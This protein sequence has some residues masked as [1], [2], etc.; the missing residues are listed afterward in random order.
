MLC[1]SLSH[2]VKHPFQVI[3]FPCVLHL[4]NDDVPF[5][6]TRFYVHPVELIVRR[7]LVTFTFQYLDDSYGFSQEHRQK[8]FQHPEISLLPQQTFDS[9]IETDIFIF[10]FTHNTSDFT[11]TLQR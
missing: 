7:S 11:F 6:V 1:D 3:Q 8:P 5:A 2:P 9:P 10:Q 4:D